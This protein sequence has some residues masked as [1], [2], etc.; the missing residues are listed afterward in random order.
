MLE[1]RESQSSSFARSLVVDGLIREIPASTRYRCACVWFVESLIVSTCVVFLVLFFE[2][3]DW[4]A[5]FRWHERW[6]I[7]WWS[8]SRSGQRWAWNYWT[9]HNGGMS[10]S[11]IEIWSGTPHCRVSEVSC[12]GTWVRWLSCSSRRIPKVGGD[13]WSGKKRVCRKAL[14]L[15]LAMSE[16]SRAHLAF[17]W[18]VLSSTAGLTITSSRRL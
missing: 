1:G 2:L 13:C 5:C 7:D 9:S 6:L 18:V 8:G 16:S 10:W 14:R 11:A 15:S 3:Q 17:R 12:R 4:V